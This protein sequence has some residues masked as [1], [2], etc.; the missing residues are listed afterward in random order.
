MVLFEYFDD[1][2]EGVRL[3]GIVYRWGKW[4]L[5]VGEGSSLYN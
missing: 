3:L 5:E 1:V 2:E 4:G